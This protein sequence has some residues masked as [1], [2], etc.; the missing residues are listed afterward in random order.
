MQTT[1][2]N[3]NL[4][5]CDSDEPRNQLISENFNKAQSSINQ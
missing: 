5:D 2:A 1:L 4:W 3:S